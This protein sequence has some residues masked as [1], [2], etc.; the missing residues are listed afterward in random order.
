MKKLNIFSII[1]ALSASLCVAVPAF[2]GTLNVTSGPTFSPPEDFSNSSIE[3]QVVGNVCHTTGDVTVTP[4]G[5]S[6]SIALAGNYSAAAGEKASVAYSFTVDLNVPGPVTYTVGGSAVV[7]GFEQSFETSGDLAPGLHQYRGQ[8]KTGQFPVSSAGE[9]SGAIT[10]HFPSGAAKAAALA[11]APG[12]LVMSIEQFD[13]QLDTTEV[14]T[15]TP[16]QPLNISTRLSVGTGENV[17]IGGLIIT[18]T[19][20][21]KVIVRGIGPSLAAAGVTGAMA[22]PVLTLYK[23]DGT[24]VGGNDNWRSDQEQQITDSSLAPSNDAEAAL[25]ATLDP[26]AYTAVLNGVADGT[27]IALVEVYDLD[28][29]TDGELGNISTR[30]F[31]QTDQDVMIGGFILGPESTTGASSVVVRAIGPSLAAAG[32]GNP[33]LDPSVELRNGDGTLVASNDN[34]MDTPERQTI[35]DNNLQPTEDAESA[36][37]AIPPPGD[38]TAIV[39]GVGDTTGVGLVEVYHLRQ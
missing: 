2:A 15:L 17:L 9:F 32:V 22:D 1:G 5:D 23:G 26:G 28:Q 21:K 3:I 6:A 35:E 18:G 38:Y 12:S 4:S 39:R 36:L 10:L 27:G 7:F 19:Q 29:T 13:I 20:P 24:V 14:Q 33:L 30:G 11:A 31:V 8:T 34:W 16:S 37:L 25:I